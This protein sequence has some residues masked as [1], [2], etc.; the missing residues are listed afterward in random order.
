MNGWS[1]GFR[2]MAVAAIVLT[3]A[4][5]S[6]DVGA[7][8][9]DGYNYCMDPGGNGVDTCCPAEAPVYCVNKNGCIPMDSMTFFD[10]SCGTKHFCSSEY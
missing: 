6:Q 7:S 9:S 10:G 8:C 5:C 4:G 3:M 1:I 2:V